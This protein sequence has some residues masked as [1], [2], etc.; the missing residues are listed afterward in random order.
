L[1]FKRDDGDYSISK[2]Q[3]SE[4][5]KIEWKNFDDCLQSIRNYNME[6]KNI[7]LRVQET[8]KKSCII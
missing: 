6:K 4:V 2:Y 7:L 1:A 5:S 8:I 3:R